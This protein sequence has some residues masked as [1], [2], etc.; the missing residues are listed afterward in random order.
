MAKH[1]IAWSRVGEQAE[2]RT[3]GGSGPGTIS[4]A[5]NR[6]NALEPAWPARLGDLAFEVLAWQAPPEPKSRYPD[7]PS[8]GGLL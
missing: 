5:G 2:F 1:E 3:A 7:R 8:S 4:L 6:V